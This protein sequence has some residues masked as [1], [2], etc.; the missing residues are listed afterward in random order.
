MLLT[1]AARHKVYHALHASHVQHQGIQ[2]STASNNSNVPMIAVK[3]PIAHLQPEAWLC[4][5][6]KVKRLRGHGVLWA[7]SL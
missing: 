2:R 1:A 3:P 5:Y 6:A 4:C 7:V